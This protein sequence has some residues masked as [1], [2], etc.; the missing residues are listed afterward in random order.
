MDVLE[1]E[2]ALITKYRTKL[3]RPFIRALQEYD[4]V[5]DNDVIAVCISGGKD[6]LVLAKLFQELAKYSDRKFAVK[7]LAMNPGFNEENLANLKSNCE[8]LNI[9]VIIKD[10]DVFQVAA[11]MGGDR[12]CFMCAKMRRGF[13][14][15]TAQELG[16]NKIA[17][18]HH[19]N[20]VIETTLLN[21]LYAGCYGTMVPKLKSQNYPG[22]ELIRPLVY[23]QE[24]DIINFMRYAEIQA[25]NCGCKV[26]SND[27]PSKRKAVKALIAEMKKQNKN[28]EMNIYRSAE[29]IN[30]NCAL[31]WKH[32]DQM[33]H[34][35]DDY[36][37]K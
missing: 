20:D 22:M 36:D 15:K 37:D 8:K 33:H 13:L 31:G 6:S 14:Y 4:L 12:P 34:F 11:K 16:C 32:N 23:V 25:M 24:K 29:N 30:L 26:A 27:L 17:L 1:I 7:Y 28:V 2:R 19:M 5:K 3:Y 21:I 10:S 9:P 18:A 35:L